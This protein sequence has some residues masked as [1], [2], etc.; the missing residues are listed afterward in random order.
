MPRQ[1]CFAGSY[2]DGAIAEEWLRTGT[3]IFVEQLEEQFLTDGGHFER[4]PMY[5]AIMVEDLLDLI[6]LDRAIP[7]VLSPSVA[8][9]AGGQGNRGACVSS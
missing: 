3:E 9:S 4:S 1:C 5:H 8:R 7:N 2:F 6:A